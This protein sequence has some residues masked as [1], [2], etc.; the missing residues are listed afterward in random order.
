MSLETLSVSSP[1]HKYC[2]DQKVHD[3]KILN[4]NKQIC[5]HKVQML[6]K[7]EMTRGNI[8]SKLSKE[9]IINCQKLCKVENT[10][11]DHPPISWGRIIG[12]ITLIAL[13]VLF[14]VGGIVASGMAFATSPFSLAFEYALLGG[15]GMG[16]GGHLLVGL[17]AYASTYGSPSIDSMIRGINLLKQSSLKKSLG[18]EKVELFNQL[19][20]LTDDQAKYKGYS[21]KSKKILPDIARLEHKRSYLVIDGSVDT[22][23]V[24]AQA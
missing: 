5:N 23:L 17:L 18:E 15:A 6:D 13:G 14:L 12:E 11:I 3:E 10:L 21:L 24:K 19:I 7:I 8:L 22:K 2:S 1:Y 20:K 4:L 9:D 16:L